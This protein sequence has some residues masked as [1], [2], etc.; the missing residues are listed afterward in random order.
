MCKLLIQKLH[1][2]HYL[3]K[4][5]VQRFQDKFYKASLRGTQGCF[6]RKLAPERKIKS[7][8]LHFHENFQCFNKLM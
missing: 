2:T 8:I 1:K 5:L 6:L 4:D 7:I 3:C